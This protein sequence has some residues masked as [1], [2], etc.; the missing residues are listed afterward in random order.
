[1]WLWLEATPCYR[2]FLQ[3]QQIFKTFS[4]Y[5]AISSDACIFILA[6]L[7]GFNDRLNRD[8]GIKTPSTMRFKLIAA[9]GPQ[10][11]RYGSWIGEWPL[12]PSHKI[13]NVAPS[14]QSYSIFYLSLRW[15]NSGLPGQL[16]TDVGVQA[17]IW[18]RGKGSGK[19]WTES[20]HICVIVCG[21]SSC[22][23]MTQSCT[24][25]LTESVPRQ[26]TEESISL[27]VPLTIVSI[28]VQSNCVTCEWL[29]NRQCPFSS[30]RHM[31]CPSNMA[32][33]SVRLHLWTI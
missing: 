21:F 2:F 11:R 4:F 7:Q 12:R 30:Y 29:P 5:S 14:P 31:N 6:F 9:N 13:N 33:I 25:R 19:D 3:Q 1:M 16:P 22:H 10:E 24:F 32:S 18:G 27:F 17:G 26:E 28:I 23:V 20:I 15:L 8:L